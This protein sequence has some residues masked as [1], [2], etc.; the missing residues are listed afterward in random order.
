MENDAKI[1]FLFPSFNV[2]QFLQKIM[3]TNNWMSKLD[4]M[5]A[6][7]HREAMTTLRDAKKCFDQEGRHSDEEFKNY[8]FQIS[9]NR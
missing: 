2:V 9:I 3:S 6:G 4:T 1:P 7:F 8:F 5:A